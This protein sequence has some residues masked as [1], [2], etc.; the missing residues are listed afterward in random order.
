MLHDPGPANWSMLRAILSGV[1]NLTQEGV[2]KRKQLSEERIAV[3]LRQ[4]ECGTAAGSAKVL[5]NRR[6]LFAFVWPKIELRRFV[7]TRVS[8]PL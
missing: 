4:A 8:G 7:L 6:R 2:M 5:L 1:L 3:A